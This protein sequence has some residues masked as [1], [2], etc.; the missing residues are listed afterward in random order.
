MRIFSFVDFLFFYSNFLDPVDYVDRTKT[1]NMVQW[2]K[3]GMSALKASLPNADWE[4]GLGLGRDSK[5]QK[6]PVRSNLPGA[7]W[8]MLPNKAETFR[9][10]YL[11]STLVVGGLRAGLHCWSVFFLF[12]NFGLVGREKRENKR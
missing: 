3:H 6:N 1:V 2:W 5:V 4:R 8:H 9:D 11:F 12:L 10:S 7:I